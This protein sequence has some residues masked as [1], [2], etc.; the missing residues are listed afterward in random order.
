LP[1]GRFV[2]QHRE[3]CVAFGGP[4]GLRQSHIHY[5]PLRF[6]VST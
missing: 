3:G 4:A 5:Q 6:S 2:A 1:G